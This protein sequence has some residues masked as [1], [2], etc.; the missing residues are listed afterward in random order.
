[1]ISVLFFNEK[2]L[3][4]FSADRWPKIFL[5]PHIRV[6]RIHGLIYFYRTTNECWA[7]V[8]NEYEAVANTHSQFAQKV[9]AEVHDPFSKQTTEDRKGRALV[10]IDILK[11]SDAM[12]I[13]IYRFFDQIEF[14]SHVILT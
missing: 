5:L 2:Y 14:R 11:Y 13:E 4:N 12:Q 7:T 10:N 1:M 3:Y 8:K 6:G 9:L